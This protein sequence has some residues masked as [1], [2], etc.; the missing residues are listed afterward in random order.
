MFINKLT[1]Y[2]DSGNTCA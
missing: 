1:Q 2:I